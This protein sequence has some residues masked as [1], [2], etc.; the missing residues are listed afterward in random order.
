MSKKVANIGGNTVA[1]EDIEKMSSANERHWK[2]SFVE[3]AGFLKT[4]QSGELEID[5][6]KITNNHHLD[7]L[8]AKLEELSK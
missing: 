4:I 6:E 7:N 8:I 2:E 5:G 3:Q 1:K